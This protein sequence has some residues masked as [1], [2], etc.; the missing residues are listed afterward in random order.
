[1]DGWPVARH[2]PRPWQS[3]WPGRGVVCPSP[4]QHHHLLLRASRRGVTCGGGRALSS[5]M[6]PDATNDRTRATMRWIMAVFYT[7]AGVAHLAAPDKFLTIT[8][9]WVPLAPQVILATGMCE[10]AGAA[11]LIT[12]PLRW[13]TG[14]LCALRLAGELQACH[15]RHR[16]ALP[17]QQLALSRTATGAAAGHHLVGALLRRCDRL[18]MAAI[19]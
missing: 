4:R 14:G 12:K 18:A 16:P 2:H 6:S 3:D 8:P 10:L 15:R 19:R 11:A 17:Q 5:R 7:I 9:D 13:C 1:M